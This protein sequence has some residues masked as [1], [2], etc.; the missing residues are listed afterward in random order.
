M[1][2]PVI[3]TIQNNPAYKELRRKRNRLGFSLTLLMLVVY[4]GYVALI[5]FDKE[6]LATPIGAGVTTVGIPI[7]MGVII[8]SVIITGLYVRR[9]NNE[10]DQLT[11]DIL[12][13]VKS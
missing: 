11:R 10:F 1:R 13:G 5:A 7:G 8:F 12:K 3:E 2:D 4:Y 6:L 9:A